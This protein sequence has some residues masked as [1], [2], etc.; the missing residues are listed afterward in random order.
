MSR[1]VVANLKGEMLDACPHCGFPVFCVLA[2]VRREWGTRELWMR[3]DGGPVESPEGFEHDGERR[4][5]GRVAR[6]ARGTCRRVVG[7]YRGR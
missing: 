6:C 1:P 7:E 4:E 5:C 2:I 3:Y